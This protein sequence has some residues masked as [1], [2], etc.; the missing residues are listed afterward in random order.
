[1]SPEEWFEW[2]KKHSENKVSERI[3]IQII[4]MLSNSPECQFLS[5]QIKSLT[6]A[7][8]ISYES[9]VVNPP[10]RMS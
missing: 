5:F 7:I 1:M 6:C 9:A 10:W 8:P 2:D 4:Q 3:D